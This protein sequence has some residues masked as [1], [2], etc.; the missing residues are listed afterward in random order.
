M[1]SRTCWLSHRTSL[2]KPKPLLLCL[3]LC[4][5]LA[6]AV[7]AFTCCFC[8]YLLRRACFGS[9]NH[10]PSDYNLFCSTFVAGQSLFSRCR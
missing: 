6:T 8:L 9:R 10:L 7:F 1:C 3:Q 2:G 4:C 5:W